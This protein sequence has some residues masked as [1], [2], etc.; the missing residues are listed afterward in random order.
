[1]YKKTDEIF[2]QAIKAT[3]YSMHLITYFCD[4]ID[5]KAGLYQELGDYQKAYDEYI[6]MAE[7]YRNRGYDVEADMM[8][9][10]AQKCNDKMN[11]QTKTTVG[12][13]RRLFFIISV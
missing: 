10:Y 4:E 8:E 5:C 9:K 12:T 13:C 6:K 2:Q 3:S 11:S 1:M 7:I